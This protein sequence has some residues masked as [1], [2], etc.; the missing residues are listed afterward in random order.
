MRKSFKRF[1][2]AALG[3]LAFVAAGFGVSGLKTANVAKAETAPL[4]I[5][6]RTLV[7]SNNVNLSFFV[8][9]GAGDKDN[10]K[11]LAR[12][13]RAVDGVAE[14]PVVLS[15][16]SAIHEEDANGD[17]VKESFYE[18][19]YKGVAAKEM[20]NVVYAY[21]YLES[22]P[23]VKSPE[24]KFS[25]VEYAHTMMGKGGDKLD[26]LIKATL[27]YGEAAAAFE[28]QNLPADYLNDYK[29]W[30]LDES[31]NAKFADGF[32]YSYVYEG[33][34]VAIQP[35]TNYIPA[36][37]VDYLENNGDGT[38]TY[39]VPA[40]LPN[41]E[42]VFVDNSDNISDADKAQTVLDAITVDTTPVAIGDTLTLD[43]T[44]VD[45]EDEV[46]ITWA[47]TG[48]TLNG[49]VV[50]FDTVGNVTLT[51]TVACGEASASDIWTITVMPKV[52]A[53]FELGDD[54][55]GESEGSTADKY[56]EIVNGY[57]L[58]ITGGSKIYTGA[59]DKKGNSCIKFGTSS[60]VGS[61]SFTVP[62][63]VTEVVLYVAKYKANAT[64]ISV[65]GESHTLMKS[66]N[67]GEYDGIVV[68]TTT[69]KTVNITTLSGGV[70]AMLNTIVFKGIPVS[71]TDKVAA[72]VSEVE[73][74]TFENVTAVGTVNLPTAGT[75]YTDVSITWEM[76]DG[77][78]TFATLENGALTINELPAEDTD[79]ILVAT[80]TCEGVSS[81][82]IEKTITVDV[83]SADQKLEEAKNALVISKNEVTGEA[84]IELPTTGLYDAT[85]EWEV[86]EDLNNLA[87]LSAAGNIL[88]IAGSDTETSVTVQATLK[89]DGATPVDA[90]FTI[91]VNAMPQAGEP[92]IAAVTFSDK[93]T[94]NTPFSSYELDDVIT[95]SAAKNNGGTAPQY[96]A[97]GTAIRVYG[98]NTFT[99][100][101][102]E[103]YKITSIVI[104]TTTSNAIT[105][106]N[107]TPTN[108]TMS[109][110]GTAVT[111]TPA[112]DGTQTIVLTNPNSSGNF[113]IAAISVTYEAV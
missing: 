76:G 72:V 108:A 105:T 37:G 51:A 96:Y 55:S 91:S 26:T 113:R 78:Y 86:I 18:Y 34:K 17:G 23:T 61:C 44:P 2:T 77:D 40:E 75:S 36:A 70:R 111:L 94:A 48:A 9:V 63:D 4:E 29:L 42:N 87:A 30:K 89:L 45:F 97:S 20:P 10:I 25:I 31:T 58:S 107:C 39:T 8:P 16:L 100:K 83:L 12:E 74:K 3:A 52:L 60:V 21:A 110:S 35:A 49:N 5:K 99:I 53:T 24:K 50:T 95:L 43:T 46:T 64:I 28:D 82:P 56:T 54:G 71:A 11:V 14:E 1:L 47:A 59:R 79:I 98:K 62:A 33:Q 104:T 57:T 41:F 66:S 13:V 90:E 84:T 81:N 85:I 67:D 27:D 112:A 15:A 93:Y 7:V 65:N 92:V 19:K 101:C 109:I 22:D 102:E 88:T 38:Y 73:E 6:G 32:D 106:S 68:D 69:N 103:G 80:V